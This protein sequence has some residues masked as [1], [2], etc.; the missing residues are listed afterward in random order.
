MI[1]HLPFLP[2]AGLVLHPSLILIRSDRRGDAPLLAHEQVHVEQ[3]R[4]VGWLRFVACYL[5][6]R[7][8][9]QAAEVEAYRVSIAHGRTFESCAAALAKHYRLG[10]TE[11]EAAAVLRAADPPTRMKGPRP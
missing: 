8:F 3:M 9:R 5:T 4:R 10:I 7:E 6:D 1:L 11:S 2:A